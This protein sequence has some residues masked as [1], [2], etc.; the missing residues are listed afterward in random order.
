MTNETMIERVNISETGLANKTLNKYVGQIARAALNVQTQAFKVAWIVAQ[1]NNEKL[2]ADDF[3][4]FEQFGEKLLGKKRATLFNMVK[5]G[6]DWVTKEGHTIFFDG[7]LDYTSAQIYAIMRIKT[8][9]EC[10]YTAVE[11]ATEWNSQGVISPLMTVE[12]IKEVVNAHNEQFKKPKRDEEDA[13]DQS[14]KVIGK[15]EITSQSTVKHA[16]EFL[17]GEEGVR[18]ISFEGIT[19]KL[20]EDQYVQTLARV[21]EIMSQFEPIMAADV[22]E[23][24]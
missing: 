9:K 6:T 10:G 21:A 3:D 14:K 19:C 5:V 24:Q 12:Q 23:V 22:I 7:E 2:W 17:E 8:P 18:M 16:L 11:K 4:S 1:I 20:T 15:A 13:E